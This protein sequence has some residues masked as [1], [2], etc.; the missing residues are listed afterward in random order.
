MILTSK[1]TNALRAEY[2]TLALPVPTSLVEMPLGRQIW[3][4]AKAAWGQV[5]FS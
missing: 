5:G 1:T 4:A 2:K 3:H